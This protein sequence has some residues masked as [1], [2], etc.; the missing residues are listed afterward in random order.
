MAKTPKTTK[1]AK[2]A[3]APRERAARTT[4]KAPAPLQTRGKLE[5]VR[6]PAAKPARAERAVVDGYPNEGK[7]VYC[8]IKSEDPL[9]FD[10][11]GVGLTLLDVTLLQ[12]GVSAVI[13][14]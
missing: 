8:I 6:M 3:A 14:E 13:V 12:L 11:A 9:R 10:Q 2:T 4:A 7:Y 5:R 1:K